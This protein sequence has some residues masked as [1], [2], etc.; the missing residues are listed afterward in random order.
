[1]EQLKGT[2]HQDWGDDVITNEFYKELSRTSFVEGITKTFK[3]LR[4]KGYS[5][6]VIQAAMHNALGNVLAE[7]TIID[8]INRRRMLGG[9]Y[10]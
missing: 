3:E 5:S 10:E 9:P 8:G 7:C 6:M 2:S 4:D 1:M